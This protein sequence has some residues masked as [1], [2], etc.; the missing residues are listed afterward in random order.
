VRGDYSQALGAPVDTGQVL[1]EVAPLESYQVVLEVDEFDVAGIA[2]GKSG[3]LIIVALPGS[4]FAVSGQKII[5]VTVAS[6]GRN[7]FL[8]ETTLD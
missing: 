3:L 6:E 5:P 2:A 4:T 8:V 7:Y 1:F